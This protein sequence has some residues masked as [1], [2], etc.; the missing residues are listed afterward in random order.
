MR[1]EM[2]TLKI[3]NYH[4]AR[5]NNELMRFQ[6]VLNKPQRYYAVLHGHDNKG[7][8]YISKD[9]LGVAHKL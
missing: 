1:K 8:F 7:Y 3:G 5:F 6:I 9:N 4:S 2:D